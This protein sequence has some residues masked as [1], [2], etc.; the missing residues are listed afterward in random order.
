MS[1]E[2]KLNRSGECVYMSQGN[3]ILSSI[4]WVCA[5]V[6]FPAFHVC[7]CVQSHIYERIFRAQENVQNESKS[8]DTFPFPSTVILCPVKWNEVLTVSLMMCLF[9]FSLVT[10]LSPLFGK[11]KRVYFTLHIDDKE[12]QVKILWFH[13]RYAKQRNMIQPS[14]HEWM[15]WVNVINEYISCEWCVQNFYSI[16]RQAKLNNGEKKKV[17][18]NHAK[19]PNLRKATKKHAW[20]RYP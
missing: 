15:R 11:S 12:C 14:E 13:Y 5:F 17:Y 3:N 4:W 16:E 10:Q 7:I 20:N 19:D 1:K 2:I 9:F 8:V 6:R 18:K